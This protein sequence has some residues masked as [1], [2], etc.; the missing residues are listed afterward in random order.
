MGGQN[1]LLKRGRLGFFSYLCGFAQGMAV[2]RA[3]NYPIACFYV[4]FAASVFLINSANTGFS[5]V[6]YTIV[7]L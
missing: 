6:A 5:P 4:L 3:K 2:N 7:V 1:E